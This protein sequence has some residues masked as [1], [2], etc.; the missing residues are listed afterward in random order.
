M[1]TA[2]L[3]IEVGT[4]QAPEGELVVPVRAYHL[5]EVCSL[6]P[7]F[8]I[9][10]L[11]AKSYDTHWLVEF[12]KPYLKEDGVLVAVQNS[13]NEEWIAPVLGPDRVMGCVLT[14]GG[15]LLEPGHVWR[16]RSI[17]HPYYTLGE[18]DGQITPRLQALVALLSDAGR[19]TT[20]TNL[21]GARWTKLV[22]NSQSSVAALC[23]RRSWTLLDHP[24]YIPTVARV[25][26]EA[27]TVGRACGYRMEPINGLTADDL[28]GSPEQIARAI[29]ADARVGGSEDSMNHVSQDL[30]RG[31]PTEVTGFLNGQVVRKGKEA[32]I[33]TPVND[34]V[35]RHFGEL[36]R[37]E[38]RA[39]I[40]NLELVG[41]A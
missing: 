16:N 13:L 9:V 37:G 19:T 36:E 35:V 27:V 20:T 14:G 21:M 38:L 22:R 29:T 2:G 15:E 12:I 3:R 17:D 30:R 33:H 32:G 5:Y 11:T 28:L 10:L 8:D 25:T 34:A 39:D 6:R 26:S 31:R 4:R 23:G 7:S 40:A 41:I 18:L 24:G 1:K